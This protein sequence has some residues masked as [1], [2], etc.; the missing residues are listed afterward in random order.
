MQKMTITSTI[1]TDGV[2]LFKSSKVAIWPVYLIV[3]EIPPS[4]RFIKKYDIVG[5]VPMTRKTKNKTFFF[6]FVKEMRALYNSGLK[7]ET[8]T[9]Q[10]NVYVI[11]SAI[12]MDL[13]ARPSVFNMTQ[14][15]G[16]NSCIF[17]EKP[18]YV[19]K[20]GKGHTRSFPY[21]E[22]KPNMRTSETIA[23]NVL[24]AVEKSKPICGFLA[25]G[26]SIIKHLPFVT[27]NENCTIDYM[28][29]ILLGITKKLVTLLIS[30]SSYQQ[31][32][33]FGHKLKD[34]DRLL[35][36]IR[37]PYLVHRTP[38]KIENNINH[39]KASEFRSFL[40]SSLCIAKFK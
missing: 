24:K 3:I 15:N 36:N 12:T 25:M 6:Q 37:V 17:C 28:H 10:Q 14:H 34:I 9:G 26:R 2:T 21:R 16:M 30:G 18:G 27:L 32:F 40:N 23:Q 4:S 5:I 7:I 20:C 19:V 35:K 29:G 38:R 8:P 31:S 39:W 13:Q 11:V 1:F 33:F 22:N